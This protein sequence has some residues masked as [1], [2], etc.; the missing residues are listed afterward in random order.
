MTVTKTTSDTGLELDQRE[1]KAGSIFN[2]T[3]DI[4]APER[5]EKEETKSAKA[6]GSL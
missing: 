1:P 4:Y 5:M 3:Y 6:Q 2:I